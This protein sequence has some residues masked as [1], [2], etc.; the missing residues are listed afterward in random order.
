MMELAAEPHHLGSPRQRQ[1]SQWLVTKLKSYGLDPQIEQFDVLF[2]TP[3]DRKVELIEPTFF[4]ASLKET[5]LLE[6]PTSG[7]SGSFPAT[8][9][10]ADGDVTAPLVREQRRKRR[11]RPARQARDE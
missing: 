9:L 4:A 7:Q 3:L 11:L 2:S 1:L 8:W 10:T 5:P 6:D